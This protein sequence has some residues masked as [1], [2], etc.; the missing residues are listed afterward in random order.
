MFAQS[1][2]GGCF[3]YDQVFSPTGTGAETAVIGV[4]GLDRFRTVQNQWESKK[5]NL[6][7]KMKISQKI[8]Q[9][10]SRCVESNGVIFF[11]NI[12]SFSIFSFLIEL[13][14]TGKILNALIFENF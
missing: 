11:S 7:S 10:T 2:A 3:L 1:L 14:M 13:L 8:S 12:S 4:T 5:L 6:N 9:N